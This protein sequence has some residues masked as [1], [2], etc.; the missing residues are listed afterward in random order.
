[1]TDKST[2]TTTITSK[3]EEK[4]LKPVLE[5]KDD[6]KSNDIFK[7]MSCIISRDDNEE[8]KIFQRD[9]YHDEHVRLFNTTEDPYI[10][11][12]DLAEFFDAK[13]N[14]KRYCRNIFKQQEEAKVKNIKMKPQVGKYFQMNKQKHLVLV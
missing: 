7:D 11:A 14:V 1:M 2:I 3:I 9:I 8:D 10:I 12:T 13:D 4:P 5:S 6:G